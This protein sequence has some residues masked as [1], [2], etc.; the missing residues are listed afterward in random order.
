MKILYPY[1]DINAP[2]TQTFQE[3]IARAKANGWCW[4]PPCG[5]KIQYYGGLDIGIASELLIAPIAGVVYARQ[6]STG[7]GNYIRIDAV[8]DSKPVNVILAHLHRIDVESG[9]S[10]AAGDQIGVSGNTGNSTGPHL[11]LEV[12]I[13]GTPVD[14][15]PLLTT[16]RIAVGEQ[17]PSLPAPPPPFDWAQVKIPSALKARVAAKPFL[18]LRA[19]PSV[20]SVILGRL[21]TGAT[22][23]ILEIFPI[24]DDVWL[25]IGYEQYCAARYRGVDMV[26]L[27]V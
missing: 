26:T 5:G 21:H 9:A 12:R 13:D 16:D 17:E 20:R 24:G 18:Y 19:A 4:Q 6:G 15:L 7:Y 1:S 11:H 2:I 25:R 3:H 14:P 8:I 10:V 27:E 22:P 23:E